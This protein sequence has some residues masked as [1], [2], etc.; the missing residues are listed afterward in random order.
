MKLVNVLLFICILISQ[1]RG[2]TIS[3]SLGK[4]LSSRFTGMETIVYNPASSYSLEDKCL[5]FDFKSLFELNEIIIGM[6]INNLFYAGIWAL[7][8]EKTRYGISA[9]KKILDFLST[10]IN[11]NYNEK[12]NGGITFQILP[13]KYLNI[14][15]GGF[16]KLNNENLIFTGID[17]KYKDFLFAGE[18]RYFSNKKINFSLGAGYRLF[19]MLILRIGSKDLKQFTAGLTVNLWNSDFNYAF[20]TDNVHHFSFKFI[21]GKIKRKIIIKRT[22]GYIPGLSRIRRLMKQK[23]YMEALRR[24]RKLEERYPEPVVK[25]LIARCVYQLKDKAK[26]I[27][28]KGVR[29]YFNGD[30]DIAKEKFQEYL[31][32]YPEDKNAQN[33]LKKTEEK[34]KL[35]Q[36]MK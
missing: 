4:N 18:V 12:I 14:N 2:G 29:S 22:R 10:G 17:F 7:N 21:P 15:L 26:K 23:K 19:N 27:Y 25:N 16:S 24:L 33:Y 9:S 5:Y 36:Q 11:L 31:L 28:E 30:Y 6:N 34:L 1:V 32:I 35:L 3:D 20:L 8:E 13:L